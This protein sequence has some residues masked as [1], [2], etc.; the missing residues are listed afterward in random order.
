[1]LK[2]YT[3]KWQNKLALSERSVTTIAILIIPVTYFYL[4]VKSNLV[5]VQGDGWSAS[6]GLRF[7]VGQLLW[8]GQAPLWNPYIFSGMPLLASIYPGALY[9]PNWFFAVLSPASA[10]NLVVITTYHLAIIGAYRYARTL[11]LD[12]IASF[13]VGV[14]FAFGGFMVTSMGQTATIATSCWLPW[15]LLAI[16]KLYRKPSPWWVIGGAVFIAIQFFGGVPQMTWHTCLLAGSYFLFSAALREQKHSRARFAGAVLM[17]T[18]GGALLSA[19]QFLPLR[20]LQQ[21]G[22]RASITYDYFSAYSFPPRQ[23]FALIFPYLFGG[24]SQLPYKTPYWG[25]WGIFVTCGYVGL[26]G[27][28][29]ALIAILGKKNPVM[30]FWIGASVVSLFLSFGSYLPL[31]VNHLLYQIP[32]YNLFRGSFRHMLELTFSIAVLAGLGMNHLRECDDKVRRSLVKLSGSLLA[33]GILFSLLVY[34]AAGSRVSNG[35]MY[36]GGGQLTGQTGDFDS[37]FLCDGQL[38]G[39]VALR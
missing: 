19:I 11:G 25:D 10:I 16:E 39:A 31:G 27:L 30:W 34:K 15:I 13:L 37:T 28:L 6:V 36:V 2:M 8:R 21:H 3:K 22:G 29:L 23:V 32:V 4:A 12:R 26:L 14:A 5:L 1:M 17:M 35:A 38:C 9:P 33:L 7:L 18:L 24:A 20:E